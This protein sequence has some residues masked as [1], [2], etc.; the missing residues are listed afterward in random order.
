MMKFLFALFFILSGVVATAQNKIE[1]L[2]IVE[3]ENYI[4]SN[5]NEVIVVNFWA[6]FCK[7]CLAEI[8]VFINVTDSFAAQKVKLLLVS[9]D[10]P[11]AYPISL[12]NFVNTNA[13]KA[14]VVWLNETD[15]DYFCNRIDKSWSGAIPATLI[16]NN[17]TGY[18]KFFEEEMSAEELSKEIEAA[19]KPV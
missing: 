11:S 8:P 4:N 5:Q 6:T 19:L 12:T 7:P 9:L 3:L 1:V 18:K 17:K 16:V 13:Y 14:T 2:K 10:M 15:A